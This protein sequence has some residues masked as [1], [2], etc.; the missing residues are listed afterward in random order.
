[1]KLSSEPLYDAGAIAVRVKE[2]AKELDV[3]FEGRSVA[4]IVALKGAMPFATDLIRKMTTPVQLEVIRAK[5]YEGTESTGE[6]TISYLP[7]GDLAG[8]TV[9]VIEDII[10][11]GYTVRAIYGALLNKNPQRVHVVTLL[12]KPSRREVEFEPDWVGFTIENQFV[13]GYG[14]DYDEAYRQLPDIHT[15]EL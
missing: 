6:A 9:V 4:A 5:S 13:V 12:D 1:M 3:A 2:L 10:D 14:M 15:M 8:K 7:D 11:T